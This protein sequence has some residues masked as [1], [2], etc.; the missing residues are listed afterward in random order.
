MGRDWRADFDTV[1]SGVREAVQS[2]EEA[3]DLGHGRVV[4]GMLLD[5]VRDAEHDLNRLIAESRTTR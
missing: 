4:L 1:I 3:E 2:Y 5:V